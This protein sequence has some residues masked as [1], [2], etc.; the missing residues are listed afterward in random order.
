MVYPILGIHLA[1]SLLFLMLFFMSAEAPQLPIPFLNRILE[2]RELQEPTAEYR[3]L[4]WFLCIVS[5]ASAFFNP[6]L[7]HSA[8]ASLEHAWTHRDFPLVMLLLNWALF[9]VAEA[10]YAFAVTLFFF[11]GKESETPRRPE[12]P[13]ML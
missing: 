13:D 7:F 11:F 1:A 10:I 2:A 6:G 5:L 9:L 8:L 4:L 3:F 12:F